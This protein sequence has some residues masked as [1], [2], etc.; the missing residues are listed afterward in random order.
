MEATDRDNE[1]D[2]STINRSD[3]RSTV[4][5][6]TISATPLVWLPS[7]VS[8]EWARW[9]EA[10]D[11]FRHKL[12]FCWMDEHRVSAKVC[13]PRRMSHNKSRWTALRWCRFRT[14][15]DVALD[16]QVKVRRRHVIFA[17][18][19]HLVP[20]VRDAGRTFYRAIWSWRAQHVLWTTTTPCNASQIFCSKFPFLLQVPFLVGLYST[21]VLESDSF[22]GF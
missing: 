18:T 3:I 7:K 21:S 9:K 20:S 22:F 17:S 14:Y 4:S 12:L 13:D 8:I 16:V 6:S 5:F 11:S 10:S 15:L 1:L 19:F 2:V